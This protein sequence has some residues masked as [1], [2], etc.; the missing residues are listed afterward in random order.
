MFY[1]YHHGA[2]IGGWHAG[3]WIFSVGGFLLLAALVVLIVM[4]ARLAANRHHMAAG[5]APMSG[6]AGGGWPGRSG[7]EAER[8]LG[9]RYARGEI[10]E[11]EYQRRLRMLREPGGGPGGPGGASPAG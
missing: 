3:F 1:R 5:G 4:V 2:G 11:E 10:D 9:E 7:G 6:P 8:I